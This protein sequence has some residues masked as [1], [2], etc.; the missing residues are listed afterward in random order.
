MEKKIDYDYLFKTIIIGDSGVGKSCLLTRFTENHYND[1]YTTTIGVDFKIKTI[2]I[3]GKL[4]KLQIWD[5][6]GQERFR[7]I[8][9]SYYRGSHL[10]ILCYDITDINT[11]ENLETW[12][13]EIKKF[14]KNTAKVVLCGTKCD[15]RQQR[16]IT[17]EEGQMYAKKHGFLFYEISSKNNI[18]IDDLFDE[19]SKLLLKDFIQSLENIE[20]KANHQYSASDYLLIKDIQ[21][22]KCCIIQ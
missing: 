22:K 12:I 17:K 9:T 11:F 14:G 10:I 1:K 16:A 4:I 21:N 19:S 13:E 6:A 15:L 20:K 3:N 5:T 2:I 7:T 18:N 8:T